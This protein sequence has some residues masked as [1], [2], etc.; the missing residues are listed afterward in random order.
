MHLNIFNEDA[1]SLVEMT[2]AINAIPFKPGRIGQMG[3]FSDN[4]LTTTY[5]SIEQ[6]AG[7]LRLVPPTPRGGPGVTLEKRGRNLRMLEIPHFQINDAINADE[8]QNI[9]AFGT[10][11]ELETVAAKVAERQGEHVDSFDVTEEYCRMGAIKGIV[12]YPTDENGNVVR[13]ALNLFTEFGIT[14]PDPIDF[15]FSAA[16]GTLLKQANGIIRLM[17]N[18]LGGTM[19]SRV[20]A[21]VGD[22]FYDDLLASPEVR[23]T[24]RNT[25][26]AEWLR[27]QQVTHGMQGASWGVFEFGGIVWENYRGQVGTEVFIE[28]DEARFFPVGV[29]GLFKTYR[30]PADYMDTVNTLARRLYSKIWPSS[31]GK[32]AEME[33]QMNALQMCLR[34]GVLLEGRAV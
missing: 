32:R 10:E 22:E 17:G 30:A 7:V 27:T 11:S 4:R 31:N 29:P 26:Q 9:R 23:E 21:L 14:E 6:K 1:F 25:S 3:I 5:A 8:V 12:T 15:D 33:A 18:A 34:P 28:P 2:D 20:H 19:F 24:F 16:D 13:P